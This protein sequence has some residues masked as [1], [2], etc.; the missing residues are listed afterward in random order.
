MPI[1]E[2]PAPHANPDAQPGPSSDVG[3]AP[4]PRQQ[5]PAPGQEE[6]EDLD[7]RL[8]FEHERLRVLI[9]EDDAIVA[10]FLQDIV[11]SAGGEI[12][13]VAASGHAA[14]GLAE[15]IRPDIIIMDVGLPGMN[16]IDAAAI[17]CARQ[18]L[19]VVFISGH[20]VET[21][22]T[23]RLGDRSGMEFLL[24]PFGAVELCDALLR[25]YV[26]GLMP[27]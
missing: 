12:V 22:V 8:R 10:S 17:I 24:K 4:N 19:S 11:M 20:N 13:G 26:S 18:R 6:Y 15:S 9:V 23:R 7:D 3:P 16:G 14:V 1:P 21:A 5:A 2:T 27:R 25:A